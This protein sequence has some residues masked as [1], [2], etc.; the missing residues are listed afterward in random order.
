MLRLG[1]MKGSA[2]LAESYHNF[3]FFK[4]ENVNQIVTD[5]QIAKV[6]GNASFGQLKQFIFSLKNYSQ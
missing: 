3:N 4:M 6:W 5:E 1:G 2:G